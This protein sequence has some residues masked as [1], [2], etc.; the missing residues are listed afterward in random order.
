MHRPFSSASSSD[1]PPQDEP[2]T[3]VQHPL[4]DGHIPIPKIDILDPFGQ[5][6]VTLDPEEDP[7]YH[8]PQSYFERPISATGVFSLDQDQDDVFFDDDSDSETA[9][10][11]RQT[12]A[13]EA[14]FDPW[15]GFNHDTDEVDAHGVPIWM[16]GY[17]LASRIADMTTEIEKEKEK[18]QKVEIERHIELDAQGRAYGTGRRK[19]SAARV[20]IFPTA[21]STKCQIRINKQDVAN[22][23]S[24]EYHREEVLKPFLATGTL[25][26]FDIMCTV[27]GGGLSGQ[28]GAIRHGLSRA[29]EKFNPD[30]RPVLKSAGFLTRDS[31]MV[32]EKKSGQPKARK[33]KQWVKR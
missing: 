31:R 15:F 33:K 18:K 23:F 22:Y 30:F 29:L 17:R 5:L 28:A 9:G 21:E 7:N 8:V 10:K 16:K 26:Q 1:E 32:E 13:D 14:A 19:T 20:W 25:G 4:R 2:K 6:K 12:I 27:K 11:S 24:L 3:T